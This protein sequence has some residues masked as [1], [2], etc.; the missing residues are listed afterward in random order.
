ML[1]LFKRAQLLS[2][3]SKLLYEFGRMA[4]AVVVEF[5]WVMIFLMENLS[6]YIK[7]L[8]VFISLATKN[9]LLR[10]YLEK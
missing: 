6:V 3:M 10:P 2:Q 9:T 8:K 4:A 5:F 1:T 7:K